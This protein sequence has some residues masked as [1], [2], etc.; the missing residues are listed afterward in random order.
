MDRLECKGFRYQGIGS[1]RL[2]R[3]AHFYKPNWHKGS[4]PSPE[5]IFLLGERLDRCSLGARRGD[6]LHRIGQTK[7]LRQVNYDRIS[8]S[9]H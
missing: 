4:A 3:T 5:E 7:F 9:Y 1:Y 2:V 8:D 6:R